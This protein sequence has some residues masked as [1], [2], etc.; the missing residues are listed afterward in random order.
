M[1]RRAPLVLPAALT[2]VLAAGCSPATTPPAD[3]A[4]ND[5]IADA[6][7]SGDACA[8]PNRLPSGSEFG[9]WTCPPPPSMPTMY[10]G[11]PTGYRCSVCTPHP[12]I[13]MPPRGDCYACAEPDGGPPQ[14]FC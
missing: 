10:L 11:Q 6:T 5:A 13:T 1:Q 14:G 9:C 8:D 12:S 7:P 4:T 2:V 3:V